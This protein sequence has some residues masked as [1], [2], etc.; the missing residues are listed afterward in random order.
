M[1][2]ISRKRVVT[3]SRAFSLFNLLFFNQLA[4][5]EGFEPSIRYSRIHT[6]QACS[7]NHSD[8][9]PE[10][11]APAFAGSAIRLQQS[12]GQLAAGIPCRC[13]VAVDGLDVGH[14]GAKRGRVYQ[15]ALTCN[16]SDGG[17]RSPGSPSAERRIARRPRRGTLESPGNARQRHTTLQ[18]GSDRQ[19][20]GV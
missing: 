4:E 17:P 19:P 2:E 14:R 20:R 10:F 12:R 13:G 9:S 18:P 3:V 11:A 8:T 1:I 16:A 6:F 5:R 7:F 15:L